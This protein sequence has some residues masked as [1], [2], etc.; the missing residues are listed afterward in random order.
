MIHESAVWSDIHNRWIF[1]PRRAS[2]ESYDEVQDEKRATNLMFI[3]ND[4][5][6]DIEIRKVGIKNEI[7]GFSSFKFVPGTNDQL[8]VALKTEEYK[9]KISSYIMVFT[10]DGEIILEDK[11]VADFKFE[12]IEFV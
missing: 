8:I 10:F 7:R 1:L 9:N 3:A 11:K 4:N 6:D 2:A 12:G 5:F